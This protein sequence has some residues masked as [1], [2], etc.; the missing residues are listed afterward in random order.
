MPEGELVVINP[1]LELS[2]P[3]NFRPVA[4]DSR[5]EIS[6][7]AVADAILT[8]RSE[9]DGCL[10]DGATTV[11]GYV[12]PLGILIGLDIL[13]DQDRSIQDCLKRQMR[14][15]SFPQHT[16]SIYSAFEFEL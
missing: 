10:T 14:A 2:D 5:S 4:G 13:S 3:I 6:E 1:Y 8:R 16:T 9:I 12:S 15:V 7:A 11:R